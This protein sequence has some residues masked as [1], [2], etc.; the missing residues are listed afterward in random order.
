M[1]NVHPAGGGRHAASDPAPPP[2]LAFSTPDGQRRA[3]PARYGPDSRRAPGGPQLI[4]NVLLGGP[5]PR[6]CV[7]VRLASADARGTAAR[8]LLDAEI[9]AALRMGRALAETQFARLFP[10]A[11][12]YDVD[13]A[14]PFVLYAPP[15]GTPVARY[16]GISTTDQRVIARDLLLAVHL[17]EG[18]GLVHRAITP[19]T[20]LWDGTSVQLWGLDAVL[21]AGRA[22]SACGQAPYAPPEQRDGRGLTDPRDAVWSSAQV[23]YHL[24]TGR[25]GHPDHAPADLSDHRVLDQT[26]RQ[27]FA[28]TA[29]ARPRPAAL[30]DVLAAQRSVQ[31]GLA[32][33]GDGLEPHRAAY[34]RALRLKAGARPAPAEEPEPGQVLCPSCLEQVRLDLSALFTTDARQQYQP[35]DPAGLD[36]PRLRAD[37]MGGAFQRCLANPDFGEHYIPVPYLTHGRPLTVAMIGQSSAGKTHLLAQM[38][39]EIADGGLKPYGL[40]WQ[41]VNRRQHAR[42]IADRVTPLRNG[43]VLAHTAGL[44]ENGFAHFAEAL[45]ITDRRGQVRPLA[46]FDLGGEDLVRTDALLRFLLGVDAMVFV[47]DPALAL[48]LPHL[49]ATRERVGVEVNRDGDVAFDTVLDRLPRSGPYID[50]ASAVVLGKADLLQFEPPVTRWLD[51]PRPAPLDPAL[52]QQ[53]SRDVYALLHRYAG[54]AWLRPFDAVRRC[55]LHVASAT[56]GREDKGRYVHGVRPRRV[57]EPLLSLLAMHGLIEVPGGSEAFAT[58]RG[59]ATHRH[60]NGEGRR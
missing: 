15:R 21:P 13:A 59:G 41:S 36:N 43:R 49:D 56:G 45:L 34:D 30:L 48:P 11:I 32:V 28:P 39:G 27:A 57:L 1:V 29:A 52:V 47:V 20:V 46:F 6:R 7:Q 5:E 51:E 40:S 50:V 31:A 16:H 26:L 38:I 42:F 2:A 25:P 53:E 22:R 8:T 17:L 24:V 54:K 9:G 58:H 55:T 23:L 10:T 33:S 44:G 35:L 14:E 4:R 12:G 18:E 37:L 19:A 60:G 3:F